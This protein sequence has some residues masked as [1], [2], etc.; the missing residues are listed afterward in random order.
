MT[1]GRTNKE[2]EKGVLRRQEIDVR[3]ICVKVRKGVRDENKNKDI[4][5]MK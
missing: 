4:I 3:K 1:T 5:Q 2:K